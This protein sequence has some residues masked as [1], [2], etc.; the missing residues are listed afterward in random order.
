MTKEELDI[1]CSYVAKIEHKTAQKENHIRARK[2]VCI[3]TQE[4]FGCIQTAIEKYNAPGVYSCCTGHQKTS[5][6]H[7]KTGK[8]LHWAYYE[9]YIKENDVS[10]LTYYSEGA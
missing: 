9:D 6:V 5:G 1:Y 3:E 2:C 10:T 7:P 4:V 8:R